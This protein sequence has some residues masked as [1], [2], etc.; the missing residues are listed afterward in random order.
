MEMTLKPK[1]SSDF[2]SFMN[3]GSDPAEDLANT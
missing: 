3:G 2:E 1:N